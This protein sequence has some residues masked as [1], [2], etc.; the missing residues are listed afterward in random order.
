MCFFG[1]VNKSST[2]DKLVTYHIWNRTHRVKN[3]F[4]DWKRQKY[5]HLK[6]RI[7]NLGRKV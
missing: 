6:I 2:Y 5:S 1:G 3:A 4:A 7:A